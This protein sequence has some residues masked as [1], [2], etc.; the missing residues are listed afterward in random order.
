MMLML[1]YSTEEPHSTEKQ[2]RIRPAHQTVP[3]TTHDNVSWQLWCLLAR[4]L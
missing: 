3:I 2:H 4:F 1:P